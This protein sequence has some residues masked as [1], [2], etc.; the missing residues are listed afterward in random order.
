MFNAAERLPIVVE[1]ILAN[2]KEEREEAL[3]QLL[4]I[5]R[6]DFVGIFTY[7]GTSAGNRPIAGSS[8]S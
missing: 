1:M 6:E 3:N 8:Y 5:Q 2:S 4:P 7:D